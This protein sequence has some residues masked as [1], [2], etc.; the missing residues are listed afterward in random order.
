[1]IICTNAYG[2]TN[3]L[4]IR[5]AAER[6]QTQISWLDSK[7]SFS[8][9]DYYDPQHMGYATLRV[10]ND[11]L[12]RPGAG[13]Q[14]HSHRDME[15]ITYVLSG[16]LQHRDSMGNGSII[17]P[18]D[19]Q[20]MSA[21]SGVTHSE[22]NPSSTE[23]LHLLQIWITPKKR[24]IEP[25]YEQKNFARAEKEGKLK[26]VASPT[27]RDGSVSLNQDVDIYAGIFTNSQHSATLK[28][29]AQH[30]VWVQVAYGAIEVNGVQ[31]NVGDGI[32]FDQVD[33]IEFKNG[34]DAEVIIFDFA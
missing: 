7:H 10:I 20:R 17:L 2:E 5:R 34:K 32:A 33:S 24:G 28:L 18:G 30:K 21:G 8:F 25:S 27:G 22:V 31:C 4:Q 3:M 12:I 14:P 9:A 6:G 15:I 11:D 19:V 26:L 13:F 1:M 16:S 29:D 23:D